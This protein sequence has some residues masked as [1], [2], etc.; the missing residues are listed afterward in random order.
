MPA[1]PFPWKYLN[2]LALVLFIGFNVLI[3]V[4]ENQ[5]YD[6]T[7]MQFANAQAWRQGYG[8]SLLYADPTDLAKAAPRV[9]EFWPPGYAVFAGTFLQLTG[10]PELAHWLVDALGFV[11]FFGGWYLMARRLIPFTVPYFPALLMLTWGFGFV[12]KWFPTVDFVAMSWHVFGMACLVEWIAGGGGRRRN[13]WLAACGLSVFG[14]C[15]FRFAYYPLTFVPAGVLLAGALL[16]NRHW[17]R[18]GLGL[19]VFT[20]LL[21]GGQVLYQHYIAG[22]VNYLNQ[23]HAGR[24]TGIHWY[25]L[26]QF[27]YFVSHSLPGSALLHL[28]EKVSDP[29]LGVLVL[30]GT[31]AVTRAARRLDQPGRQ[32]FYGWLGVVWGSFLLNIAFLVFLSLRYPP[33]SWGPWTYVQEIRYFALNMVTVAATVVLLACWKGSPVPRFLRYAQIIL[34]ILVGVHA[35]AHAPFKSRVKEPVTPSEP[36]STASVVYERVRQAPGPVVFA[37]DQINNYWDVIPMTSMG[38][39]GAM[40]G[41][42]ILKADALVQSPRCSAPVTVLVVIVHTAPPGLDELYRKYNARQVGT[43][44]KG[45]KEGLALM[46]FT[47]PATMA[48][49]DSRAAR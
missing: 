4:K 40:G 39:F 44:G 49:A 22:S 10:N 47:L 1:K 26:E 13:G 16:G 42:A 33:E 19:L 45:I 41:G 30:A 5:M 9:V 31:V 17:W 37:T 38:I 11:L 21:V 23:R 46:E 32:I 29:L 12:F 2:L 18:P 35:Y 28:P 24:G 43:V 25:N 34:A 20:A 7:R 48:P 36:F 3:R 27:T 8:V 6:D 15:F 14:A